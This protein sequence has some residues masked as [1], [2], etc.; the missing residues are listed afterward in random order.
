MSKN[1]YF[2]SLGGASGDMLLG[3][4][5]GLGINLDEL[6]NE[7]KKLNQQADK[8]RGDAS[9]R[10]DAVESKSNQSNK[11]LDNTSRNT[12]APKPS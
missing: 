5:L 11:T 1:I 8:A 4:F 2:E 9:K 7:L 10:V 12:K 3:A 6:I